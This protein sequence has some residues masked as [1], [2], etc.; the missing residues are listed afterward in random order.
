MTEVHTLRGELRRCIKDYVRRWRSNRTGNTT[1]A[2]LA[3]MALVLCDEP[4]TITE[5]MCWIQLHS[6]ESF[7]TTN[8]H[9]TKSDYGQSRFDMCGEPMKQLGDHLEAF[10][11]LQNEVND[12]ITNLTVPIHYIDQPGSKRWTYSMSGANAFLRRRL[13]PYTIDTPISHF[14]IM[15]LPVEVR[16]MTF[17]FA[18]LLPRS[19]VWYDFQTRY[20]SG[21]ERYIALRAWT[22]DRDSVPS[23]Y[24]PNTWNTD[25]NSPRAQPKALFRVDLGSHLALFR[26]SKLIY[27]E[28]FPCFYHQNVFYIPDDYAFLKLFR[29]LSD[30][31][32]CHLT[33]VVWRWTKTEPPSEKH[34]QQFAALPRLRTLVIDTTVEEDEQSD[35]MF[36][37]NRRAGLSASDVSHLSAIKGL[38]EVVFFGPIA[39]HKQFLRS[40]MLG[41]KD[42]TDLGIA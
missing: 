41:R 14:R 11:H 34:V 3:V 28:A 26:V 35:F 5:T 20:Q 42:G 8:N 7:D 16:E 18:L 2:E 21:E 36:N 40:Q 33:H 38:Q 15:D 27:K 29:N 32:F 23:Q 12:S 13:F 9:A 10:S 25:R 37:W 31:Q 17:E 1:T 19:G 24:L 4:L 30:K 6:H 22:R 39:I